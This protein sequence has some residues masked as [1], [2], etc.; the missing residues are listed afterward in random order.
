MNILDKIK[1]IE[2]L[3]ITCP[4]C[5]GEGGDEVQERVWQD[6]YV[7]GDCHGELESWKITP[8]IFRNVLSFLDGG[9]GKSLEELTCYDPVAHNC[10]GSC[11][12]ASDCLLAQP[13]WCNISP[14]IVMMDIINEAIKNKEAMTIYDDPEFKSEMRKL[15]CELKKATRN[16][17]Y[18]R[19][20]TIKF[21][22]DS[23]IDDD[24]LYIKSD[25]AIELGL[26]YLLEKGIIKNYD[27]K[28]IYIMTEIKHDE[29]K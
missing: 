7:C 24:E 22:V 5:N 15:I 8:E 1:E 11:Q 9:S 3:T 18:I 29:D 23:D 10:P 2:D 28:K 4:A 16:Q 17:K 26:D 12:G 14:E 25:G 6:C 19:T 13:D 21:E 27:N 20:V